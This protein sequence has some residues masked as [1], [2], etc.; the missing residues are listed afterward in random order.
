M[1]DSKPLKEIKAET[2][3]GEIN[4]DAAR[5]LYIDET[6]EFRSINNAELRELKTDLSGRVKCA[7]DGCAE[8]V[9]NCL[10][11]A[12]LQ[13]GDKHYKEGEKRFLACRQNDLWLLSLR[14]DVVRLIQAKLKCALQGMDCA[15]ESEG[16]SE[17]MALMS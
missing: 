10:N 13:W 3:Y 5:Q 11:N 14:E 8:K 9:H 4:P 6:D 12:L 2:T 1:S 7:C 17:P 15:A 16:K